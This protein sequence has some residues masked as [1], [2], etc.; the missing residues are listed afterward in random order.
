MKN[1]IHF[2]NIKN[3]SEIKTKVCN[4]LLLLIYLTMLS[5]WKDKWVDS[6]Q[7]YLLK[8]IQYLKYL[9]ELLLRHT[10]IVI[11]VKNN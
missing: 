3:K 7:Y 1:H 6:I 2:K 4:V 5:L 9:P 11:Q 10:I 8:I